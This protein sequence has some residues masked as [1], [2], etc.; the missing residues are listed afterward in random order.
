MIRKL[1]LSRSGELKHVKLAGKDEVMGEM[2]KDG[3]GLDLEGL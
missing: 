1:R 3:G 2:I